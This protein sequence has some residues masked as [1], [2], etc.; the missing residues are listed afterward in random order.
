[1]SACL[2]E[3]VELKIARFTKG[4]SPNIA[5]K[6][7]LQSYLSFDDVCEL[8]IKVAKQLKGRK[9]YHTSLTRGPFTHNDIEILSQVKTLDKEKGIA[10][11]HQRG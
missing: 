11:S 3:V 5:N 10:T 9:S 2:N 4:L 7:D 1:M 6:V 8:A